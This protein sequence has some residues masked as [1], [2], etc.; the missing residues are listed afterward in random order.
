MKNNA[1]KWEILNYEILMYLGA[2]VIQRL[3]FISRPDFLN[4]TG[5]LVQNAGTEVKAL[6]IRI[7]ADIFLERKSGSDDINIDDLLPS[8][9]T[10]QAVVAHNLEK[11]YSD[12]LKIANLEHPPRWF[13]NKFLAHPDKRRSNKFNWNPIIDRMDP[14]LRAVFTTLPEEHLP[15]L[16][17]LKNLK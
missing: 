15:A 6:H 4:L 10:D 11:A 5:R 13:L 7:L 1:N 8:W 17:E 9:R 12:T 3:V 16:A 14:H 2:Q